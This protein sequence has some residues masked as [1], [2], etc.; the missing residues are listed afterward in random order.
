MQQGS[1]LVEQIA[2]HLEVYQNAMYKLILMKRLTC[3]QNEVPSE[4][5]VASEVDTGSR[6]E[7]AMAGSESIMKRRN[8]KA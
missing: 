8:V 7:K 4:V 2:R 3:A 6:I 1:L 5:P